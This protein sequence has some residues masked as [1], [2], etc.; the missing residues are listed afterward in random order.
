[1]FSSLVKRFSARARGSRSHLQTEGDHLLQ[2]LVKLGRRTSHGVCRAVNV[3]GSTAA[4]V[5][6][7]IFK[8]AGAA[9]LDTVGEED[10]PINR[11][12]DGLDRK[13]QKE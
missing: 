9:V 3:T 13:R 4:V 8:V 2:S 11:S 12:T 10:R 1:M 5:A 6:G 7:G